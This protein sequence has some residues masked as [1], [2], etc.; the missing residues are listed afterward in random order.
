MSCAKFVP[1]QGGDKD[2]TPPQILA[3]GS[4]AN[5]QTN[6]QERKIELEFDEY[7]AL[8]NPSKE[9]FVSPPLDYPLKVKER[10][11]ILTIEFNED[12][13]LRENTT[14]QIN[15]GKSIKDFTEG[16]ALE[17]Y[18]M[19]FSTGSFIDSLSMKGTVEDTEGQPVKDVLVVLHENLSDTCLS[20]LRPDYLTRTDENG[21]FVLSN[22]RAD[23]FNIYALED[24]NVSFT[25]DQESERIGFLDS[26]IFLTEVDSTAYTLLLFDE[27]DALRLIETTHR[28]DGLVKAVF[29]RPPEEVEVL[30]ADID[31]NN[32]YVETVKDTIL[33]W[34]DKLEQ[35][36]LTIYINGQG[37]SDT[38]K[39]RK[40]K[41]SISSVPLKNTDTQLVINHTDTIKISFNKPLSTI[42]TSLISISDTSLQ[43][44]IIES[45]VMDNQFWLRTSL[46]AGSTYSIKLDSASVTDRYGTQNKDSLILSLRTQDPEKLGDIKL[47]VK[48]EDTLT[49]VI[50]IMKD[51]EEVGRFSTAETMEYVMNRVI[52]GQYKATILQD[53]NNNGQ[54]TAGSLSEKRLPEKTKEINLEE[55]KPGWEL[56]SELLI[57]EIFDGTKGN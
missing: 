1:L 2:E 57:Q 4:T 20:T 44:D 36:S 12:E 39:T 25:Y 47:T 29:N 3:S 19:V 15:L 50:T 8:S 48:N 21:N 11:R 52:P 40:P 46:E 28:S 22:L 53:L 35:D 38:I 41:K 42:D 37:I 26:T 24:Q 54:W 31:S 18:S 30:I 7:I 33:V 32:T 49:Y 51:E 14:Y 17:D 43:Y 55:L 56:D 34:H 23:T 45:G 6:F 5:M 16:N 10:G 13:V 9:I 27:E